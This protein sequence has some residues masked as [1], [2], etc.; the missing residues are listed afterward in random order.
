MMGPPTVA[1]P[2]ASKLLAAEGRG[3]FSPDTCLLTDGAG[4]WGGSRGLSAA[5]APSGLPPIPAPSEPVGP[6]DGAATEDAGVREEKTQTSPREAPRPC[7]SPGR[8]SS[9]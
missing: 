8:R 7:H 3:D 9:Q 1:S 6:Q 2:A 4:G 5:S